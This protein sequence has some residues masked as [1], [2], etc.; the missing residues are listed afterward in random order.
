MHP[1]PAHAKT[2]QEGFT[3]I[4]LM[5]TVALIGILAAIAMSLYTAFTA[6]GFNDQAKADLMS[7][8]SAQE[9]Y[10]ADNNSYGADTGAVQFS[11]H[12]G[13]TVIFSVNGNSFN[14]CAKHL[15][16][17]KIYGYDSDTRQYR[18]Q[19]SAID[20]ALAACPAATTGDDFVGWQPMQ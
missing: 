9:R 10:F 18:Q 16:G 19:D 12:A 1:H 4:E 17:D 8:V 2:H 7:A 13:V 6:R 5:I 15:R 11:P 3:L 20:T 14:A